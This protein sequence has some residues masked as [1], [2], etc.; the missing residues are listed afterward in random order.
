MIKK[1][2]YIVLV[3]NLILKASVGIYPKEKIRKQKVRFNISI[4]ANDNIKTKNDISEFVSYEDVIKNVKNTINRGHTPL[5]ENLAQNI[6]E[7]CLINK[8]ILKIEIMIEKLETFKETESVGIKI[9][10][11]NKK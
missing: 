2:K 7:K 8:R 9:I 5:I 3:K 1:E 4:T 10:R 6:A 11:M